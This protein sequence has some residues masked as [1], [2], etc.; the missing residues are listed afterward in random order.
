MSRIFRIGILGL[1]HDHVWTNLKELHATGKAT[2]VAAAD[3]HAELLD[4]VRQQFGC[5]TYANAETLLAQ[6]S[7][8][9][10]Y[11]Y[12][13]N[14][15][16]VALTE[17]AAAR[18]L[19]VLVEKPMAADLAGADRMLTAVRRAKVRLMVNWPFAWWPQLQK[20][21]QMAHAGEIGELWQVKYRAGHAGPREMGCSPYF[22]DWLYDPNRNGG[23]A[24]IDY[25]CYGVLL[26]RCLLGMP[27]RVVGVTGRLCKEEITVEDNGIIVMTYPRALALAEGSWTQMDKLTAYRTAIYG[28]RGTLLVEPRQGGR[29]LLATAEHPDG[30]DIEVT[31]APPEASNASACFLH[32]LETGQPFPELCDDQPCRDVQEI[33]DAG[34]LSAA[35]GQEVSLPLRSE[36]LQ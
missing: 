5:A 8:D 32:G 19:H 30:T 15:A 17:Q 2:V 35:R 28:T 20:A 9:A 11:V 31:A 22:C 10:V 1:T 16:G 23:G 3:P 34:L 29:L 7:L 24:L 26:A 13:D 36:G 14:A 25:C 4:K 33:L 18:G 12:G 6:E 21:L 27:R